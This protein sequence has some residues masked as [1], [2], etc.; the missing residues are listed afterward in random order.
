MLLFGDAATATLLGRSGRQWSMGKFV[1]GTNGKQWMDLCVGE[2]RKLSM[3][4]RAIF[5]FSVVRVPECL[6]QTLAVNNMTMD[7]INRV[8]LHQGSRYIVDTIGERM[9]ARSKTIFS[10]SDIGN[11]VSSSIPLLL[12]ESVNEADR[13]I[14]VAGFGVGLSWA[15]T[16]LT[17]LATD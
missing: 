17:G 7:N 11:T 8:I 10:E 4:G 1:F 12:T 9:R 3:N 16:V 14:L 5:M 2:S 13:S 6:R 15:A